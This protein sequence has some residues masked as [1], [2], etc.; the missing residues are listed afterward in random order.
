MVAKLNN[1]FEKLKSEKEAE[2]Q[3]LKEQLRDIMFYMEA[4]MKIEE[5]PLREE[6]VEG[7][8]VVGQ[9]AET[10]GPSKGRRKKRN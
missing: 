5:S 10:P 1:D 7:Q 8:V 6:I 4:Q 9:S 2:I 3:D